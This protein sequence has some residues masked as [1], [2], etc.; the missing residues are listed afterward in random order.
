MFEE[1]DEVAPRPLADLR[2]PEAPTDTGVQ[3]PEVFQSPFRGGGF[4]ASAN[5]LVHDHAL[6][7]S[8]DDEWR[9][10]KPLI[11]N[12]KPSRRLRAHETREFL[13]A[14]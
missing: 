3:F 5:I 13:N 1:I 11:P 10:L 7:L 2:S 9:I 4:V 8:R 14:I 12:P 6:L